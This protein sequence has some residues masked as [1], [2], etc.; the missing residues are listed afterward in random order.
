MFS[1]SGDNNIVNYKYV[2]KDHN[3]LAVNMLI[4]VFS[5]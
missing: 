5:L 2:Y 3:S 1:F 4:S